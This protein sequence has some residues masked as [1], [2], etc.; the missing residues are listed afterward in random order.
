MLPGGANTE[1]DCS[2]DAL[3]G[4]SSINEYKLVNRREESME[5]AGN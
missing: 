2:D 4:E 3:G 1:A 5:H